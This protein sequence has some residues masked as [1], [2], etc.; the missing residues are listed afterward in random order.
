MC[1][2]VR[3]ELDGLVL[4]T[5]FQ[6][7]PNLGDVVELKEPTVVAFKIQVLHHQLGINLPVFALT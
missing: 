2:S 1:N 3:N 7:L 5:Q 4:S 6:I